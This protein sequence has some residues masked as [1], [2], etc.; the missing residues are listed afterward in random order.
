M[1]TPAAMMVPNGVLKPREPVNWFTATGAVIIA[2]VVPNV[3]AIMNSFQTAMNTRMA[4]VKT[5]G[6]ANGMMICRNAWAGVQPSTMAEC[7]SSTG[8]CRKYAVRFHTH[9]GRPNDSDGR[10]SAW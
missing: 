3:F 10:I 7:S 1:R 5:P 4:V 9:N 6:A 2:L 8:N